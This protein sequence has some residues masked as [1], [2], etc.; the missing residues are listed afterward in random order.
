MLD[1]NVQRLRYEE[2]VREHRGLVGEGSGEC[3]RRARPESHVAEYSQYWRLRAYASSHLGNSPALER[4]ERLPDE[5][6]GS[7]FHP[8]A[9]R[10][11]SVVMKRDLDGCG[12]ANSRSEAVR[13]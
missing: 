1:L 13:Y 4:W 6:C 12:S 11:Y 7:S 8:L 9:L 3:G 5:G 10:E 2:E